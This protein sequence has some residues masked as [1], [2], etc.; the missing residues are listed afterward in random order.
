MAYQATNT[1]EMRQVVD[2][3]ALVGMVSSW[4]GQKGTH[5]SSTSP[6]ADT[7]VS[8]T[9]SDPQKAGKG[10]GGVGVSGLPPETDP[11]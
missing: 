8:S 5:P 6:G 10:G 4:T 9:L 3:E 2:L 1:P 7:H 11:E